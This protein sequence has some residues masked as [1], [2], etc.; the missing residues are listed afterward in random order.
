V[1]SAWLVH[2]Y[3]ASGALLAF[4]ALV[5]IVDDRY[6]EAFFWLACAL[7]VDATD[8]VVARRY[9]VGDRIPWFDGRKLDDII[10]YVTYVFVP[11]FLVWH[12]ALVP[13]PVSLWVVAAILIASAYGFSRD[14]AK[15]TDFLF[16]GFPSYWNV[17]VFYLYVAQW[18][19]VTNAVILLVLTVMVF[20]PLHYVY[21]SRTPTWKTLTVGLGVVWAAL[22]CVLLWQAPDVSRTLFWVSMAFPAYYVFLSLRLSAG[23]RDSTLATR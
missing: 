8:G 6:R 15:T 7:V 18:A 16:T 5:R 10:D 14:D 19:P 1:I 22:M 12:A 17:V 13:D 3:T 4:L 11:A 20:V 21:P 23:R 2:L 9:A